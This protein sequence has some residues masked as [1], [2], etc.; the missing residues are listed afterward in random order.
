MTKLIAALI[1]AVFLFAFYHIVM[2]YEKVKD[3]KEDEAK[4]A[5]A[6]QVIG[7]SLHGM[8]TYQLEATLHRA[9]AEGAAGLGRWLKAY[10]DKVKDPRRAWIQLDYCVLLARDNLPE[11]KRLFREVKQRTAPSSPV[12]PRIQELSKTYE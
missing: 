11:A 4:K 12:W 8:P 3:E 2:Y 10:G 6:A 7:Q 5:A 1:V 9:E